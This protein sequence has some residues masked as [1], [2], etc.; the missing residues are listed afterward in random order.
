MKR[1]DTAGCV[2]AGYKTILCKNNDNVR[3]KLRIPHTNK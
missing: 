3:E 1:K 2:Y